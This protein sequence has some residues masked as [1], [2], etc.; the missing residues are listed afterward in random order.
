MANKEKACK[1]C[2]MIFEGTSCP[3]C[4]GTEGTDSFKGK[5]TVIDSENSELAKHTGIKSKGIFAL[6]LR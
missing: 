4:Q 6:R 5:I 2:K 1:H 3:N